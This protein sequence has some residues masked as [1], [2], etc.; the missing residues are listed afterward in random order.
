MANILQVAANSA[1]VGS[2]AGTVAGLLP[3]L[4]LWAF[5]S[6]ATGQDTVTGSHDVV[7]PN[8]DWQV[9]LQPDGSSLVLSPGMAGEQA[10]TSR[11]FRFFGK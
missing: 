1:G 7:L 9:Q 8:P 5:S 4:V 11:R 2:Y 3:A 6:S 10:E